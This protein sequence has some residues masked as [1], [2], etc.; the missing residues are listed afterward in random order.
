MSGRGDV[1]GRACTDEVVDQ[2]Y[3]I[4]PGWNF[5]RA[6]ANRETERLTRPCTI[7]CPHP[8]PLPLIPATTL[9]VL[10]RVRVMNLY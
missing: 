1:D 7:Q 8:R 10:F 6:A 3:V 2:H 9:L 4:F 5:A